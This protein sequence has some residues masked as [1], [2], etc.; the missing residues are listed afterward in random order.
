[1]QGEITQSEHFGGFLRR[2]REARGLSVGDLSRATKI[3]AQVIERLEAAKLDALPGQVYVRGFVLAYAR[4]VGLD[5]NEALNRLRMHIARVE[6]REPE[7]TVPHKAIVPAPVEPDEISPV[8]R[9]R[10]GVVMVVL[11]ILVVA[12][13]T[14]SLLLRHGPGAGAGLS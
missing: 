10:M 11:L 13:L 2:G 14:L 12:T 1:M 8:G 5:E 7:V 3:K 6:H 9:R 4:Q